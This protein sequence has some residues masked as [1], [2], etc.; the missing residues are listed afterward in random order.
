V[1]ALQAPEA[2]AAPASL[3][4]VGITPGQLREARKG[5]EALLM[6]KGFKRPF[7]TANVDDLMGRAQVELIGKMRRGEHV[8]S[9]VGLLITIAYRR[10]QN[11]LTSKERAPAFVGIEAVAEVADDEEAGPEH[12]TLNRDREAKIHAAVARLTVDERKIVALEFFGRMNLSQAARELGWDESKARRRHKAAM[13]HLH[14]LLGVESADD[15]VVDVAFFC[16]LVT[17]LR[18]PVRF[19]ALREL[20]TVGQWV[21]DAVAAVAGRVEYLAHRGNEQLAGNP[22]AATV[23]QGAGRAAKVCGAAALCVVAVGVVTVAQH[24]STPQ[25]KETA[26]SR[27]APSSRTAPLEGAAQ[28]SAAST[29]DGLPGAGAAGAR[30]GATGQGGGE[31]SGRQAVAEAS[32]PHASQPSPRQATEAIEESSRPEAGPQIAHP[33]AGPSGES[34]ETAKEAGGES[35]AA[36]RAATEFRGL[37][38]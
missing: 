7:L 36:S 12:T 14:D 26:K 9:P 31:S 21:G 22:A 30:G 8:D 23:A 10:A 34:V 11:L 6:S 32:A 28:P 3:A 38:E 1:K 25:A 24:G 2:G 35:A 20:E 19:S 15:L 17:A 16:W 27:R 37:L 5:F 4:E 33:A 18:L 13:G 29:A